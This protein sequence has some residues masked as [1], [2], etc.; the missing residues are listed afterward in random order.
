MGVQIVNTAWEW[1]GSRWWRVDFHAHTP[2]SYDYQPESARENPDWAGWIK[3]ARDAGIQAIAIT[4]HNTAEAVGPLQ[5]AAAE[6]EGAPVLFPGVELTASGGSHLL[7]LLDPARQQQHVEELLSRVG[8]S[9]DQ[10]GRQESR[11]PLSAEKILDELGN[12][13]L[14][15]GAHVNGSK[16]VL[17][18]GPERNPVLKHPFFAAAEI[19]PCHEIESGWLDGSLPEIG[20]RIPQVW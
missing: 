7:V 19:H 10:R 3:A 11:S 20:R 14:V 13:A 4:D 1:P 9:T 16:G 2:K 17:E 6:I 18:L 8:V 12:E 15:L 5:E